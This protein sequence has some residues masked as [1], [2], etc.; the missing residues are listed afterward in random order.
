[1]TEDRRL[2]WIWLAELFGQGSVT[3]SRLILKYS[4][5]KMIYDSKGADLECDDFFTERRIDE[6][7]LKL[8]NNSTERAAEIM[9]RCSKLGISII[10]PDSDAYPNKLKTIRDFPLV[11]YCRGKIPENVGYLLTAVVGTRNMTD[12]GRR[13]AYTL[14]AG[15][16]LGGGVIVSGMA[17]GADSMALIGAL[18]AGGRVIAVLGSGVD[19]IYPREHKELYYKITHSGAVIS[20]YPPG[21]PPNGKNFPVRN[22]IMSGL[23]DATIVVEAD[24]KSGAMITARQCLEQGRKLFAVPGK[25]GEAGSEG[26]NSLIRDG[27]LPVMTPEDVLSEFSHEYMRTVNVDIAHARLRNL[28]FDNMSRDAMSRSRIGVGGGVRNY[29]GTGSY[30]GRLK[31]FEAAKNSGTTQSVH[32]SHEEIPVNRNDDI[33]TQNNTSQ[34][35]KIIKAPAEIVSSFLKGKKENNNIKNEKQIVNSEKKFIPAKKIELDMLDEN[36]I[37][38]YNSMKPNVPVLP[39][40]LA[41]DTMSV[42]DIMSSLTILEMAGAVESGGGGYYMRTS[43]DDIMQSQND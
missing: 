6:I 16:V 1:M 41:D 36:E 31:D 10:T 22:R 18:E 15:I 39:D 32:E 7:K 2:Y 12:Y 9:D 4:D 35:K 30:G 25:V 11:L 37:K 27:A 29:Y 5:P 8:L 19:V 28:D 38:V 40:E 14:G 43:P 20:E 21:T 17:L 23:S 24:M 3:A 26:P 33:K 13:V 42:S 34:V